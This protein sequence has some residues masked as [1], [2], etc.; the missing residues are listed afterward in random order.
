MAYLYAAQGVRFPRLC[1]LID[2]GASVCCHCDVFRRAG[3]PT[4]P[5][6]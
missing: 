5:Q 2:I 4:S 1:V 6:F 3:C